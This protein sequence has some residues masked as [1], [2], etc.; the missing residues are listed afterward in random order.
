LTLLALPLSYATPRQGRF[1]KLALAILIYIVY[2]NV[3]GLGKT[4]LENGDIP[5]WLGLWWIHFAFFAA[6][7]Y[8]LLKQ[9]K[10]L[11]RWFGR[12]SPA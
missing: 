6:A 4:W 1:G 8:L 3:L 11:L 10:A 5:V 12:R 7:I 2:A 9:N